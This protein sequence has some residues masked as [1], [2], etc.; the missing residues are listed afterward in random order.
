MD[1]SGTQTCDPPFQSMHLIVPPRA[2]FLII[3]RE[4]T[5]LGFQL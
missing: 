1:S 2:A 4:E 5:F 3:Q